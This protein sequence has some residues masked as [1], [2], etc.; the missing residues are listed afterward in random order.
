MGL[1]SDG[2]FDPINVFKMPYFKRQNTID[3]CVE[4]NHL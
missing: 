4:L 3:L 2:L 1:Y